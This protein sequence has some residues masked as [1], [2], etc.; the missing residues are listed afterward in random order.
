MNSP[1]LRVICVLSAIV[2]ATACGKGPNEEMNLHAFPNQLPEAPQVITNALEAPSWLSGHPIVADD[3]YI[4]IADRDNDAL[5]ILDADSLE[6]LHDVPVGGYPEQLVVGPSGAAWVVCRDDG[7]VARVPADAALPDLT[8]IVGTEPIGI[9]LSVDGSRAYVSV[10]GSQEIVVLDTLDGSELQRAAGGERMRSIAV[11]P[12]GWLGLVHENAGIVRI[13]LTADGSLDLEHTLPT[14]K[15]RLGL[16]SDATMG[17]LNRGSSLQGSRAVGAT[18]HPGTGA[19]LVPHTQSAPGAANDNVITTTNSDSYS[20][21][22]SNVDNRAFD[23]PSRPVDTVVTVVDDSEENVVA[24]RHSVQDPTTGAAM[25]TL[26][27][28]PMDIAHHPT[29]S[30]ALVVGEGTDNVLVLNTL[31]PDPTAAP[32]GIIDVGMG[33]RGVTFSPDGER[34]FVLNAHGFTVSE[35]D[36]TPFLN[37]K[38][39][40]DNHVKDAVVTDDDDFGFSSG[41]MDMAPMMPPETHEDGSST[42]VVLG[43]FATEFVRPLHF[44]HAR[45][46]SFGEDPASEAV[47]RGRAI[48]F[49]ANNASVS[50]AGTFACATC[51]LEGADDGLVWVTTGPRQTI[52]LNGRLA[53]TGPFNWLGTKSN[54]LDNMAQT[55]ERMGGNGLGSSQLE[56]LRAFLLEGLRAPINPHLSPAGLTEIQQ[57]GKAIFGREDV[58]CASCHSGENLTNGESYDVNTSTD[59]ERANRFK[60]IEQGEDLPPPGFF[61]TPSLRGVWRSAPYMH[62][63]MAKDLREALE[64]TSGTM[65]DIS[66]L[67]EY[68]IQ[69]LVEYLKTL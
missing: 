8:V 31:V 38:T 59:S 16:P 58:G 63:G 68:E 60:R 24:G 61:N 2:L 25:H 29:H 40:D 64:M 41:G 27:A 69:A 14:R 23:L 22:S 51:H 1:L 35:L 67:E 62:N 13:E 42:T 43:T 56:D 49:N 17:F 9:A 32:I 12:E 4:Y 18:I 37:M 44:A 33:P 20:G 3:D 54:L 52:Q 7:H 45:E 65:G 55:I 47:R 36:M 10:R 11:S 66:M 39:L 15:L 21:G 53:D 46:V 28:L 26:V 57:D 19:M 6:V 34:A 5:K 50:H 48:F 30:I